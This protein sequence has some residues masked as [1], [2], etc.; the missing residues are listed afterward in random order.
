MRAAGCDCQHWGRHS[1]LTHETTPVA[2]TYTSAVPQTAPEAGSHKVHPQCV[3]PKL[4]SGRRTYHTFLM[5]R[6]R[7]CLSA[8]QGRDLGGGGGGNKKDAN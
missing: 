7:N 2:R 1:P 8:I 3:E 5:V 4:P 6:P